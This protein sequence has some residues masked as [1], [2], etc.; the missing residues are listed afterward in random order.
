MQDLYAMNVDSVMIYL[1]TNIFFFFLNQQF[2]TRRMKADCGSYFR[3]YIHRTR[4]T[5]ETK[6]RKEERRNEKDKRT[7]RKID[8]KEEGKI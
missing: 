2:I 5:F 7:N 1:D 6:R 8:R 4:T 3:N